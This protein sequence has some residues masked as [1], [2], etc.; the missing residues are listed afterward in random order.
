VIGTLAQQ[1]G[2][3]A[4]LARGCR[5]DALR[6]R[7]PA[8]P[9]QGWL[10][11]WPQ[12]RD[13]RVTRRGR[14]LPVRSPAR[15]QSAR[16]AKYWQA[17][18]SPDPRSSGRPAHPA[19]GVVQVRRAHRW[20][21]EH[22]PELAGRVECLPYGGGRGPASLRGRSGVREGRRRAWAAMTAGGGF[23]AFPASDGRDFHA[24]GSGECF[25]AVAD[26]FAALGE[27]V[28]CALP[29]QCADPAFADRVRPWCPDRGLDN[30]GALGVEDG[31]KAGGVLGVPISDHELERCL[32]VQQQV[33]RLLRYSG[34]GGVGATGS[35][36]R[37]WPG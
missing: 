12:G 16:A 11:P 37:S 32:Q 22:E 10:A 4:A 9:H 19:L 17:W 23:A 18:R 34:T 28:V 36:W 2:R 5:V 31:V 7:C 27:S 24:Q 20:N 26:D 1:C 25:L 14:C 33:T 3:I 29:A 13:V 6:L 8:A 30:R 15:P 21:G 35:C